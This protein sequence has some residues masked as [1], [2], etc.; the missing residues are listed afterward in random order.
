MCVLAEKKPLCKYISIP[1]KF[2]REISK[3]CF[4]R[5]GGGDLKRL[6]MDVHCAQEERERVTLK[7]DGCGWGSGGGVRCGWLYAQRMFSKLIITRQRKTRKL[8]WYIPRTNFVLSN[9]LLTCFS[10]GLWIRIKNYKINNI[11]LI[12]LCKHQKWMASEYSLNLYSKSRL[13]TD[14]VLVS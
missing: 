12:L 14:I 3:H 8:L 2:L 10:D 11:I 13:N 4:S 5:S 1:I 6:N 7:P 9:R